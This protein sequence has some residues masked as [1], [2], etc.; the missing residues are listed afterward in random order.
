MATK[1]FKSSAGYRF[2]DLY[3]LMNIV[4]LETLAFCRKHLSPTDD[5]CGR[6]FDQMTQAA[7]SGVK[8]LTEG[9]ERQATSMQ[10]ALKLLDVAR[11]SLCELRDDFLTYLMD[12]DTPPWPQK[13]VKAQEVFDVWLKEATFSEDINHD[14]CVH[15]ITERAR[16][17][18]WFS[19]DGITAANAILLLITRSLSMLSSLMERKGEEFTEEGGFSERMTQVRVEAKRAQGKPAGV[20]DEDAPKCPK[21]GAPMRHREGASGPFRGCTAY[22][23]CRG[24]RPL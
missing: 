16:F 18:K 23:T 14:V 22:P 17:A 1:L 19:A 2:T 12:H 4:Q 9:S 3:V 6:Q 20:N 13:S 15:I 11:V 24:T 8:N 10:T 5:P 7:R 21:C